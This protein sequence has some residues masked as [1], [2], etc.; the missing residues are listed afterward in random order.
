MAQPRGVVDVVGAQEP[1]GLLRGVVH[2]VG[3]A[4]RRQVERHP[5]RDR[6]RAPRRAMRSS[7]SS[8]VTTRKPRLAGT[9]QHRLGQP[10]QR[11]QF[12]RGATRQRRDIRQRARVAAPARCSAA[13]ARAAPCRDACPAASSPTGPTCPARSRRR[14]RWLRMR[15]ANGSWSRFSQATLSHLA[16]VVR[17][18]RA[19]SEEGHA[20]AVSYGPDAHDPK[21][22]GRLARGPRRRRR[23]ARRR[24][25]VSRSRRRR[26]AARGARQRPAVFRDHADAG[27][28][29]GAGAG[30]PLQ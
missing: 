23:P 3:D 11:A 9:P 10:A 14:R 17:L 13:S 16:V 8:Q 22:R 28:R 21:R 27:R 2:L 1:R 6:P 30:I 7:A 4:A 19:E 29:P 24:R 5:L 15:H 20:Q 18:L 25:R 26:G 12:A